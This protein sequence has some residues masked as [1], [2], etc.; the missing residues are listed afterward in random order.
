MHYPSIQNRRF[1]GHVMAKLP[2]WPW[3][4]VQNLSHR[5]IPGEDATDSSFV[6]PPALRPLACVFMWDWRS[7]YLSIA[8]L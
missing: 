4:L 1:S 8:H 6:S 7:S 5:G 2:F 3:K